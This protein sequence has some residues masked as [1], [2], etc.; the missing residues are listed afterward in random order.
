MMK[1][2][3]GDIFASQRRSDAVAIERSFGAAHSMADFAGTR[4]AMWMD[5]YSADPTY[6]EALERRDG[7]ERARELL[8]LDWHI[9]IYPNLLLHTR[10]NHYRVI[11]PCPWTTP[12]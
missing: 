12:R 11:N 4:G 3:Y 9:M 5:A 10:L 6:L 7:P 2:K 8:E 1:E